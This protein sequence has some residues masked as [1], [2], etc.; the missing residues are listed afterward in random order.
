[1]KINKENLS[2][3]LAFAAPVIM[4]LI[5]VAVIY[6]PNLY[7]KPQTDFIY[8]E[9]SYNHTYTVDSNGRVNE[10]SQNSP[11]SIPPAPPVSP[12]PAMPPGSDYTQ[13]YYYDIAKNTSTPIDLNAAQKYKLNGS[14][15]SPDGYTIE[16]G[17]NSE[18]IFPI[19]ISS[20]T[21]YNNRYIQG[22]GASRKLNLPV[23][24][25]FYGYNFQLIGWV[26]K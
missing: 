24:N 1:M 15:Q 20:S 8:A 22:H 19:F 6:I 4:I 18:G 21:D 7:Y 11:K 25:N 2:L 26:I 3:I 16:Y 5:V 12:A 23:P 17:S 13:L 14:V 10:T 9:S